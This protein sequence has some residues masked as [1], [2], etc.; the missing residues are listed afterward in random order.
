MGEQNRYVK[1]SCC[2]SPNN[3]HLLIATVLPS[4]TSLYFTEQ[5]YTA[6]SNVKL[7]PSE[8]RMWRSVDVMR[9]YTMT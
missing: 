4:V 7:V 5:N 2:F 6:H 3:E 9:P 8:A 1:P